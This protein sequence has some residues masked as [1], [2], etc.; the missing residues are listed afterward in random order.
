M[1]QRDDLLV[2]H[3]GASDDHHKQDQAHRDIQILLAY[4]KAEGKPEP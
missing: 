1:D 4:L 2:I 3:Q